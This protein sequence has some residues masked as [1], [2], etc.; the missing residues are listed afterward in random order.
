MGVNFVERQ[1][2]LCGHS[3]E[4]V[5]HD[6]GYDVLLFTYDDDGEVEPG[7]LFIQVKATEHLRLLGTSQ[8]AAVRV[9]VSN[10]RA[11]VS[12][13]LPVILVVY[14]ASNDVA[15]WLHV[16]AEYP[17]EKSGHVLRARGLKTVHVP[18]A[19]R[20][21]SNAVRALRRLKNRLVR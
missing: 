17:A 4:R 15:Y 13:I 7:V 18:L 20:F 8:R 2:L 9:D 16:Q 19:Q 10:L 6:Y 14:D 12:E 21:D 11:W 1:V 3:I 5:T